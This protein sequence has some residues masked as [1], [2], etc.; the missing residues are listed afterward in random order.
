MNDN[1]ITM[2]RGI[3]RFLLSALIMCVFSLNA[4]AYERIGIVSDAILTQINP[5][6]D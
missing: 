3:I 2:T 1:L 4:N 6:N 5:Y